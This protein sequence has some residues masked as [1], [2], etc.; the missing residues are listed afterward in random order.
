MEADSASNLRFS[1]TRSHEIISLLHVFPRDKSHKS[2]TWICKTTKHSIDSNMLKFVGIAVVAAALLVGYSFM[3]G[4]RPCFNVALDFTKRWDVYLARCQ[5]YKSSLPQNEDTFNPVIEGQLGYLHKM[6]GEYDEALDI[7][8]SKNIPWVK[9]TIFPLLKVE[10]VSDIAEFTRLIITVVDNV[11]KVA[12]LYRIK[13][14]Y[15]KGLDILIEAREAI[16]FS[17][18]SAFKSLQLFSLEASLL[19]MAE[20][21]YADKKD[22]YRAAILKAAQRYYFSNRSQSPADSIAAD[23]PPR[24]H[25]FRFPTKV[26]YFCIGLIF[27]WSSRLLKYHILKRFLLACALSIP[28]LLLAMAASGW[29]NITGLERLSFVAQMVSNYASMNTLALKLYDEGRCEILAYSY[30]EM[31]LIR[32]SGLSPFAG[33]MLVYERLHLDSLVNDLTETIFE[34]AALDT[35]SG[36]DQVVANAYASLAISYATRGEKVQAAKYMELAKIESEKKKPL[37]MEEEF[38]PDEFAYIKVEL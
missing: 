14:E 27:L 13:G 8:E 12:D 28:F 26:L 32:T 18:E 21:A 33:A 25:Q 22:E 31:V 24:S 23:C 15:K 2:Q 6:I 35:E 19:D 34:I 4:E 7:Y 36:P 29:N 30:E 9:G 38:P 11:E 20:L 17:G 1:F 37:T 16:L 10:T 3:P 5:A